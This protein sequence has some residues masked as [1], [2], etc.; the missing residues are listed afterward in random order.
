[1]DQPR[2]P[3]EERPATLADKAG[4]SPGS[5][6][7]IGP[8]IKDEVKIHIMS[9]D[10]ARFEELSNANL[11]D[12]TRCLAN[13]GV[14]W[15]NVSGIHDVDLISA[16]GKQFGLHPLTM[17]DIVN[18]A[19]RP[20][21]EEFERY[22]FLVLKMASYNEEQK[23]IEM[24]NI[25]LVLGEGW[26]LSFQER[27][28]DVFRPVRDRIRSG[29]GRLRKCKADYLAYAL[30]DAVVDE[31]FVILEQLGEYIE[32]LEDDIVVTPQMP[33]LQSVY[34]LKRN[35][36][37]LRK[38]VWPLREEIGAIEK[39]ESPLIAATTRPF[40]RDLY[41]HTIQVI[42]MV[43]THRDILGNMHDTYLSSV[44]NRMNDIIK[45]LTIIATIFIPLTFVAGVY[46]MNFQ[47]MPE[48]KWAWGYP[49]VL[50]FMAMIALGMIVYFKRRKWI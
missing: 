26:V 25:S 6:I 45:V 19:Q 35:V 5:L 33:Q 50:L 13:P 7:Y 37:M 36:L 29:K 44:N 12:V 31:Y 47:Y 15:I 39:S 30:T 40:L 49:A 23:L 9:Y 18:T 42:D 27:P 10:E 8:S 16:L 4:L 1:M 3:L 22:I 17:E 41:D 11:G 34:R 28:G 38:S 21:A 14:T 24:E 20:K 43:E 2:N 48:L 46:G 32:E